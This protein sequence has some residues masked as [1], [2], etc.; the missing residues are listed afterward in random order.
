MVDPLNNGDEHLGW[1]VLS[2]ES[3]TEGIKESLLES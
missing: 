3:L 1:G 2:N